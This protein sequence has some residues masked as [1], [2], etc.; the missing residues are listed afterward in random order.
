[1]VGESRDCGKAMS[2]VDQFA[3]LASFA[4]G[5]SHHSGPQPLWN[6]FP[7]FAHYVAYIFEVKEATICADAMAALRAAVQLGLASSLLVFNSAQY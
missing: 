6:L 1:M 2:I 7:K 5:F 4:T 3:C